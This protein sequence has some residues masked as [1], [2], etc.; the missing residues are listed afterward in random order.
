MK[1]ISQRL[2]LGAFAAVLLAGCMADQTTAPTRSVT[3]GRASLDQSTMDEYGYIFACKSGGPAGTYH[4]H[5]DVQG[6]GQLT[7][8]A[9]PDATVE[10]DGVNRACTLMAWVDDAASWNNG[11]TAQITMTE[12]QLTP[13]Q[14]VDSVQVYNSTTGIMES[15]PNVT[16]VTHAFKFADRLWFKFYNGAV[17][18]P[19]PTPGYVRACKVGGPAGT[20]TF[21]AD[22][23]GGGTYTLPSGGTSTVTFNGTTPACATLYVPTGT[24][25]DGVKATIEVSEI[26][27]ANTLEVKSITVTTNGTAGTPVSNTS[28]TST[29]VAF[30]D[31]VSVD[32]VNGVKPVTTGN[33]GCTPGYWKVK[34]HWDSWVGTGYTTT[35]LLNTVF[36][37][38]ASYTV[39]NKAMGSYSM[40]DGLSFQGGSTL[41][42]KA[43]ILVRAAV[44]A[45]LNAGKTN[46]AYPAT[47]SQI[48]TAVNSALASANA[49]TITNLATLLDKANNGLGGCPLN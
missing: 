46:V 4:F 11:V 23:L 2:G 34:Q 13:D 40:V 15:Y 25:G 33:Q 12:T 22:V 21:H 8:S 41:S 5:M 49:T 16:S 44:A 39:K 9:A 17:V 31:V 3:P 29:T 1:S 24:W 30:T 19:P 7:N 20:Y 36:V 10:F 48:I 37:I 6:G 32:F 26:N 27:I 42:G 28:S 14:H 43:E 35:Q 38:P 47:K 18:A 45:V